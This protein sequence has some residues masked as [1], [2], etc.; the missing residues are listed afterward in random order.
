MTDSDG[1]ELRHARSEG[2]IGGRMFQWLSDRFRRRADAGE[3][4]QAPNRRGGFCAP[5]MLARRVAN[6][7]AGTPV[8]IVEPFGGSIMV[9]VADA[10]GDTLDVLVVGRQLLT[11]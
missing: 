1:P 2:G 4:A 3:A 11:V 8:T 5:V 6:W 9:E 7:P 10:S